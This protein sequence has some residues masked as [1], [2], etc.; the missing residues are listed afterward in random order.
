MTTWHW[1]RHAPTH[2]KSFVGWRDVPAD[3]SD[4]AAFDR[5]DAYLPTK[6]LVISSDL[7]R[8]VRTADAL[9]A[10]T[11]MRLPHQS[12]LRE[13]HFGWWDGMRFDDIAAR[14]PVLSRTFWESPGA[15]KAPGGESWDMAAA[16]VDAVVGAL[17]TRYPDAQIIAVAHFGAILTQVQRALGVSASE[18]L[19]HKIDN[20]SVTRIVWDA[21]AG[22][23]PQINHLP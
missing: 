22:Q 7:Q 2:Q 16:R 13:V 10:G 8:S 18:V 1:V 6:A 21:G 15:I 12:G 23:V 3:L 11:R 17:N 19:A 4:R 9:T 14:D 20:L 5:L